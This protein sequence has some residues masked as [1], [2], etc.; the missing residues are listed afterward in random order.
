MTKLYLSKFKSIDEK[1][2]NKILDVI[3]ED[4]KMRA[5]SYTDEFKRGRYLYSEVL[6]MYLIEKDFG[7]K[8][9]IIKGKVGQQ[10]IVENYKGIYISKSYSDDYILLGISSDSKIGVDIEKVE[11]IDY[12]TLKYFFT[13][14][15]QRFIK[16]SKNSINAF[17]QIWTLKESFI[18]CNG[19]GLA[20][21]VKN[22]EIIPTSISETQS[23]HPINEKSL[24]IKDCTLNSYYYKDN[25][26][27]VCKE[28]NNNIS[29]LEIVEIQLEKELLK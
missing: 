11:N 9:V 28:D 13:E 1:L 18:K 20:Y 22:L 27:A 25:N 21:P 3:D 12:G 19:Q 29:N 24:I 15:E 5:Q 16:G 10:P 14:Q 7:I 2:Q 26:I 23:I 4:R 6:I 8:N 17:G